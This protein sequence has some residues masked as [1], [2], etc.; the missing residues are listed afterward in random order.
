MLGRS[1]GARDLVLASIR[2]AVNGEVEGTN[3][4]GTGA[5]E[6]VSHPVARLDGERRWKC[7]SGAGGCQ[8]GESGDSKVHVELV[9]VLIVDEV[10]RRL[11]AVQADWG[12]VN[13]LLML[14]RP[15]SGAQ[16]LLYL[17]SPESAMLNTK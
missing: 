11:V 1:I 8:H 4:V 15:K 6:G 14:M 13:C 12:V 5:L 10:L 17:F 16:Q 7:E 9:F 3:V 2:F